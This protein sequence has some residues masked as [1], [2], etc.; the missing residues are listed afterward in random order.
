MRPIYI[1]K[2]TTFK[3]VRK[4]L[5]DHGYIIVKE[6]DGYRVYVKYHPNGPSIFDMD[7]DD[8]ID[9]GRRINS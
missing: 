7:I 3:E 9:R 2:P 4:F 5:S 1:T 6:N 8:A